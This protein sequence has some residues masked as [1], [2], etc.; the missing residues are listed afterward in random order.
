MK[1]EDLALIQNPDGGF[2]MFHSM[3]GDR[4]ITT[5]KAL[6]RFLFLGLDKDVPIVK[7]TLEYVKKCLNR[8][9]ITPDRREKVLNWDVFEELMFS[10]WLNIFH[11]QDQKVS[12]VQEIWKNIIE[13]SIVDDK[14]SSLVYK[15]QYRLVFGNKGTREISPATF[16]MVCLLKDKLT[17]DKKEAYFKYIMENGIY[18]IYDRSLYE[19]PAVFDSKTSTYYLIAI[20]LISPYIV[21]KDDL[22]FVKK[23]IYENRSKNGY[24][25]MSSI[26]PDGIIFPKSNNW[27]KYEYKLKDINDFINDVLFTLESDIK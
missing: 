23:W 6:R 12:L 4:S 15:I 5:E 14:F 20:E 21:S 24:W 26:K 22:N 11:V 8:K 7:K 25:Y 19:V 18:Y 9:I 2:G 13:N 3:S 1:I 10:A 27:R 16:Y 17:K